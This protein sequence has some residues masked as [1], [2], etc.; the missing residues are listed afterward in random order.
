[1]MPVLD[2]QPGW[3][4]VGV[5]VPPVAPMPSVWVLASDVTRFRTPYRIVVELARTRLVLFRD[6]RPVLCAPDG[7]GVTAAPTPPGHFFVALLARAPN[8]TYGSFVMV[9]S[10]F[11]SA[12]TDW[13]E[14]NLTPSTIE[15]PLN[16]EA[17]IGA[18]GARLTT[19]SVRLL[20]GDLDRLRAVP[21]GSPVDVAQTIESAVP[22][23]TL[24]HAASSTRG[25]GT[26]DPCLALRKPQR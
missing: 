5:L 26:S 10:A 7:L 3:L 22:S 14:G 25:A 19:G 11:G 16:S 20:N 18:T 15:G 2:S 6:A 23:R 8:P 12:A 4:K 9:T 21:A 1:M 13:H 24:R 17:A